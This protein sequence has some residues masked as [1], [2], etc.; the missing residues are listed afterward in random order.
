MTIITN[1]SALLNGHTPS[2]LIPKSV[3]K[4]NGNINRRDWD[5]DG[6]FCDWQK[7]QNTKDHA[8]YPLNNGEYTKTN[9]QYEGNNSH[10]HTNGDLSHHQSTMEYAERPP[11]SVNYNMGCISINKKMLILKLLFFTFYGA[12]GCLLPF[13]TIHMRH[14][15][16]SMEEITWINMV[17]PL[18]ALFGAP[19]VS[20]L[21]DRMGHYRLITIVCMLLTAALHTSLL[22]V[23]PTDAPNS[24]STSLVLT[25]NTSGAALMLDPCTDTCP[26]KEHFIDASFRIS[27]CHH[28]CSEGDDAGAVDPVMR[29]YSDNNEIN[30][31]ISFSDPSTELQFSRSLHRHYL[32][33]TAD[34]QRCVY[35]QEYFNMSSGNQYTGMVCSKAPDNCVVVCDAEELS[36]GGPYLQPHDLCSTSSGNVPGSRR[37][38]FWVYFIARSFGETCNAILI[39]MLDA[40]ALTMVEQHKG[41]FG[42]EKISGTLAVSIFAPLCGM[43]VDKE[44]GMF[45][46]YN[47]GPVFYVFD[48]LMLISAFITMMLHIDIQ[49]PKRSLLTNISLLVRCLEFRTLL[50]LV[51]ILG[52]F[53]GYLKTFI[54]IHLENL[55]ATK[56][57]MGLTT[58]ISIILSLPFLYKSA[59]VLEYCGHHYIIMLAFVG[60]CVRFTGFSYITEPWW[61][62]P[63]EAL[64]PFT[65]NLM[66]VSAATLAYKLAPKDLVAT[67]Q[68]ILWVSHYNIGRFVG[69][70]VGGFITTEYGAVPVFKGA[71]VLSAVFG[72]LYLAIYQCIKYKRTH[73]PPQSK[74]SPVRENG[75]VPN[76]HYAPVSGDDTRC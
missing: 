35:P 53:S 71:A 68:S 31:F 44:F 6:G 13:L 28:L 15:G 66:M 67:A 17:L 55:G 62:L 29:L 42:R 26:T 22:F 49:I 37:L 30:E 5:E 34:G 72:A 58:S 38:T 65:L 1:K 33:D 70:F 36:N 32:L 39:A 54:Y 11:P 2:S 63:L 46:S 50:L 75:V 76:G 8:Q 4:E 57:L 7:G 25:C 21:A 69:I 3:A 43:L 10:S 24:G 20:I 48:A 45:S 41:D 12:F 18:S 51:L 23:P 61:S 9:G 64:E 16:L 60:Y 19:F 40:V 74:P 59:K 47:Y 27:K 52:T 14:L 56:L 73:Q